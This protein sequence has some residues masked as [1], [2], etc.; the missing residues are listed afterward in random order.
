MKI[1]AI[2]AIERF[3]GIKRKTSRRWSTRL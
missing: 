3:Y 1:E 2:I